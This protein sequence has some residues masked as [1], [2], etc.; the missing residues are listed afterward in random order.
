MWEI[1]KTQRNIFE[2]KGN[3]RDHLSLVNA[4]DVLEV[5]W[6][7]GVNSF[8]AILISSSLL[9]ITACEKMRSV[10]LFKRWAP[11]LFDFLIRFDCKKKNITWN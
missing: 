1:E 3:G 2:R 4:F 9:L 7:P 8:I 10:G 5:C 6:L 11:T